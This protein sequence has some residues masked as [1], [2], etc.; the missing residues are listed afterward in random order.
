MFERHMNKKTLKVLFISFFF[1]P[2]GGAG[3]QRPMKFIKYLP[4][5][6]W[7][8]TVLTSNSV[9]YH[10]IDH[11]LMDE[12]RSVPFDL[13]RTGIFELKMVYEWMYKFRLNGLAHSM[14]NWEFK[15]D[16]PDRRIGWLPK[17][18]VAGFKMIQREKPDVIFSTSAP[19]TSHLIGLLLKQKTGLP[20]VADFRDE[21]TDTPY[22][23]Y[24]AFSKSV[25]LFLEN[26][27]LKNA[28]CVVSVNHEITRLLSAKRPAREKS[29]FV[30]IPNGFDE[31]DIQR[32]IA[33]RTD[34]NG[35]FI[36]TH[37]GS[38][39]AS[40][41]PDAF[42]KSLAELLE[43]GKLDRDQVEVRFIG[44]PADAKLVADLNLQDCVNNSIGFVPHEN[45]LRYLA[46]S[47][48]VLLIVRD[49]GAKQVTTGKLFEYLALGKPI[50][51]IGSKGTDGGDIIE[52]TN[53]GVNLTADDREGISSAILNLYSDWKNGGSRFRP[54]AAE[55]NKY[56]RKNIAR[57][58]S[59]KLDALINEPNS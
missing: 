53:T 2:L 21:W 39:Y 32:A 56:S 50:L 30:T 45:A 8:A 1:P 33:G 44:S 26:K 37:V 34:S 54:N 49:K 40:R 55:I 28:D 38:F 12:I 5:F 36:F 29:K 43:Q 52:K 59:L 51:G 6:G 18:Y 13:V 4:Q 23:E 7:Q 11:S 20:W 35:K 41:K 42:L 15:F 16:L 25:N 27:V 22:F 17:A 31:E 24:G 47:S 14:R 57:C 9:D 19:F 48:A 58:L 46:E 3:C 10:N